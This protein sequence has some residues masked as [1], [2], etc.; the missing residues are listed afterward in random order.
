NSGNIRQIKEIRSFLYRYP[1]FYILLVNTCYS[2]DNILV[3]VSRKDNVIFENILNA[4][5]TSWILIIPNK[6][7]PLHAEIEPKTQNCVERCKVVKTLFKG[8]TS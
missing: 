1:L 8:L 5:K 6:Y 4:K 2:I 7:L 3:F